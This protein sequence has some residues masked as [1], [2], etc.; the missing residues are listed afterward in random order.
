MLQL[1]AVIDRLLAQ[2]VTAPL[3]AMLTG[4]ELLLAKGQ[5][6]GW[7]WGWVQWVRG[8]VGWVGGQASC[9]PGTGCALRWSPAGDAHW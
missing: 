4:V 9:T 7:Q 5:V 6:G 3:K 2:P 1:S 8:W